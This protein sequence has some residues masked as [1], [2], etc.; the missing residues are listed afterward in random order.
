MTVPTINVAPFGLPKNGFPQLNRNVGSAPSTMSEHTSSGDPEAARAAADAR[1]EQDSLKQSS[2]GSR[3]TVPPEST[4]GR[5]V[6]AL[7]CA[8]HSSAFKQLEDMFGGYGAFTH[9]ESNK[10]EIWFDGGSNKINS[11]SPELNDIPGGKALFD[12][13]MVIAKKLAPYGT[14]SRRDVYQRDWPGHTPNTVDSNVVRQFIYGQRPKALPDHHVPAEILNKTGEA[15]TQHNLLAALKEQI[16]APGA[17]PDLESIVVEIAPHSVFWR[18]D[19]PQPVTMNL[20]QLMAAYG[21]HVPTTLEALANLERVLFAPPLSAPREGNCGGLLT[22]SVPLGEDAQEKIVETV[23]AW[24][25]L[26]TQVPLDAEGKAPSLFEYLKRAVPESVRALAATHP[27]AF[28]NALIDTHQARALGKQL[29]EAIGALPTATSGQEALLTAL[30]LE[31]NRSSAGVER[32]HLAGYNLRQQDNVGRTPAEIVKRFE[33]HME[34]IVG[35]EMAKVAAYQLL[36]MSAPEFLVKDVPP[37]VV[38]GSLQWVMFSAEVFRREQSTPGSS[39]GKRYDQIREHGA[40]EPVALE[41]EYQSKAAAVQ[42]VVDWGI[43]KGIIKQNSEGYSAETIA[44]V[45][46]AMEAEANRL[47]ATLKGITAS[48]PTRREL[49][50]AELTRVYGEEHAHLFEK[51]ILTRQSGISSLT[52]SLLNLYMSGT[53]DASWNSTISTFP[54]EVLHPGM[55]A[56]PDI[57]KDFFE[58]FDAYTDSFSKT[59]GE[60][61]QY[62]VSQLRDE[63]RKRFEFGG[64]E[65]RYLSQ[66][67]ASDFPKDSESNA[68]FQMFGSGAFLITTALKGETVKYIYSPQSG[69]IIKE[70]DPLPGVPEG[71]SVKSSRRAPFFSLNVG[72]ER[73]GLTTIWSTGGANELEEPHTLKPRNTSSE[74]SGM[75][76]RQ[77]SHLY[78]HA[79]GQLKDAA[80]GMSDSEKSSDRA[81]IFNNFILSLL[82]FHDLVKNI[83]EGNKHD[84]AVSGVFDFIGLFNPAA[85]GGFKAASVGAKGVSSSLTFLKGAAKSGLKAANPLGAVYDV[86]S[87]LFKLGK[88]ALNAGGPVTL[89]SFA[90][91][92]RISGRGWSIPHGGSKQSIAEGTY[93]RAGERSSN[94][95]VVAGKQGNNWYALD[96]QTLKPYGPVLKDFTP[97]T[98]KELRNLRYDMGTS[99][100]DGSGPVETVGE[101]QENESGPT[102]PEQPSH[103]QAAR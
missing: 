64:V 87:G 99:I 3:V 96:L 15:E 52:D 26:Q 54:N 2:A 16:E 37:S 81:K 61:F 34:S 75:F 53:L 101:F 74:R 12:N 13:L 65:T 63:D 95:P 85:K 49:A 1:V 66:V 76:A 72:A 41:Q 62:H 38:F 40:L 43:A 23:S 31:A 24:K 86:G 93:R 60:M 70:G 78:K 14:L 84:A 25:A 18:E 42:A 73:Y 32:D 39:A 98:V 92:L 57:K 48:L 91:K 59:A 36:A 83:I 11:D 29:Q 56:L 69:G 68:L 50:L 82:P 19:Q 80:N 79:V 67:E 46:A 8:T 33:T 103:L 5:W 28:L 21:L 77:I 90:N 20:K 94:T 58:K 7:K 6:Q 17:K 102:P 27:E 44:S 10:G 51:Q 71:W 30:G 55:K 22:K 4:L 89:S 47:A 35:P 45:T 100:K 88:T 9:I 97:I